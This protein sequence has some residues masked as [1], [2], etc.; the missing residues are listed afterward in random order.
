HCLREVLRHPLSM[1]VALAQ[2]VL[3]SVVSLFCGKF[4]KSD[5]LGQIWGNASSGGVAYTKIIGCL[6]DSM[7]SRALP[8]PYGLG[9]ILRNASTIIVA[10]ADIEFGF[11]KTMFGSSTVPFN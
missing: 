3:G 4:P 11:A 9:V 7:T 1:S 5:R 10:T 8:P 2:I 6:C